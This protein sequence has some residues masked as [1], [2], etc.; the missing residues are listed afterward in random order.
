MEQT[1]N[2]TTY[3]S[4]KA[5]FLMAKQ[6][7]KECHVKRNPNRVAGLSTPSPKSTLH[8]DPHQTGRGSRAP[9]STVHE[10]RI[11]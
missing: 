2:F 1:L 3:Y 6:G 7:I 10:R 8:E 11:L 4:F 9:F 5:M